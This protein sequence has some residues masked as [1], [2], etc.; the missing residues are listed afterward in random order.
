[1]EASFLEIYNE[2]IRDLLGS[3]EDSQKHDIKIV[4]NGK[5]NSESTEVM[6]TNLKSFEV[7]G[8]SQVRNFNKLVTF[9]FLLVF[10]GCKAVFY[11]LFRCQSCCRKRPKTVRLLPQSATRDPAEA[12]VC[13]SLSLQAKTS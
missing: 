2:M 9:L 11:F 3:G 10:C 4:N 12:I 7:I 1:M 13:S 6:V 8:E 5:S